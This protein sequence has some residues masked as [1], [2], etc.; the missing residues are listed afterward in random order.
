MVGGL[1]YHPVLLFSRFLL[2]SFY[3]EECCYILTSCAL[4]VICMRNTTVSPISSWYNFFFSGVL[5]KFPCA[6]CSKERW[7]TTYTPHRVSEDLNFSAWSCITQLVT[8]CPLLK[9]F[10]NLTL[11]GKGLFS[12]YIAAGAM[13]HRVCHHGKV[14][15]S[16]PTNASS[17]I[18]VL[19]VIFE[20]WLQRLMRIDWTN[21]TEQKPRRNLREGEQHKMTS[22][23]FPDTF[24]LYV[25]TLC[26]L[27][28]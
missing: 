3:L 7:K 14:W 28:P 2:C 1:Q 17:H 24:I 4:S 12:H 9:P 11:C 27:P 23:W 21:P 15:E 10:W 19:S 5:Q 13:G 26:Y 18:C 8:W 25:L 6:Y 16:G 20:H 22:C